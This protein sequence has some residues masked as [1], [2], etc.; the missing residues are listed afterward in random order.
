MHQY[1]AKTS[2]EMISQILDMAKM[3]F[4]FKS[5]IYIFTYIVKMKRCFIR[6]HSTLLNVI[7]QLDYHLDT[8]F[9]SQI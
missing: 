3:K 6:F 7:I 2:T 9:I 8:F 1:N 4:N 5:M